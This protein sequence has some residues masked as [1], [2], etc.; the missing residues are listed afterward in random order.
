V[1]KSEILLESGTNELEI[2]EFYINE[3]DPETGEQRTGYYGVNVAKVLEVI[4]CPEGMARPESA[5]NPCF[6]GA[7]D[8]RGKALPILDL[9][10]WLAL[11]KVD[12]E[13]EVIMVTEFNKRVTGF[14]VSGVT[15]IHRVSWGE[16][17]SPSSY[18]ANMESNCV[19]GMVKIDDHFVLL[20]DLE[21][22]LAELDPGSLSHK[23]GSAKGEGRRV[24]VAEDSTS[25][26]M[27][28]KDKLEVA[29]FIVETVNDGEEAYK[30]L[31]AAKERAAAEARP[32]HD[33][34]SLVVSDIEMPRMDGYTLTRRVKEDDSLKRLPVILFSS[35]ITETLRH[36]GESV[37]A[38]DQISKPE[39]GDL[40][41]RAAELIKKY[42]AT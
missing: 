1:S 21:K 17:E 19:T 24:L 4:E 35:L 8:L 16:V 7:I 14:L 41:D 22:I 27:L 12:S 5:P 3:T 9:A 11:D 15:Q 38:D 36:K 6:M 40:A 26:R 20:V 29:G 23:G 39:F 31:V 34:C 32:L 37:G 33:F 2:I 30:R 28:L 25:M 10:V 42:Q 13:N 18:L